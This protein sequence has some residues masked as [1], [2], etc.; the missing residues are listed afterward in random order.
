MPPPPCIITITG[1][2]LS[3]AFGGKFNVPQI[4]FVFSGILPVK[5]SFM[6]IVGI[7]SNSNT[8]PSPFHFLAGGGPLLDDTVVGIRKF[9]ANKKV[10]I[11]INCHHITKAYYS[12]RYHT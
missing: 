5:K 11:I 12:V 10:V 8:S 3:A 2:F 6:V 9:K 4:V 1:T 7:D